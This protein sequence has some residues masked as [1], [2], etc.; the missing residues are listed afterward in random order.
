MTSI[1]VVCSGNICRSPIAEGLMRDAL[2]SRFGSEAPVV[3]SAGTIAVDGAPPSEG[4][5]TAADERGSDIAAHRARR[6][7]LDLARA[8]DLIV[9]M[10]GEHREW[11][12][13]APEVAA[14][15]F[16]LKELVR[17]LGSLPQVAPGA[18]PDTLPARVAEASEA[19]ARGFA[20]NPLDEDIADPLGMPLQTYRAVAWELDD[21]I[22]RL[23][24][25]LYGAGRLSA[26]G[27]G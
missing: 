18:G 4:S 22:G 13:D 3:S 23:L 27:E 21:L 14:R 7:T 11:L 26:A 15:T 19:R 5:V 6:L 10:A 12:A 1:L 17:L 24:D 9:G 20:G 2:V 25:R 8:A 16:T